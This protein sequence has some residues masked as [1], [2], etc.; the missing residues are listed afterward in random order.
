[1]L[2]RRVAQSALFLASVAISNTAF[3]ALTDEPLTQEGVPLTT[4]GCR[5]G[6]PFPISIGVNVSLTGEKCDHPC[7]AA[8][9]AGNDAIRMVNAHQTR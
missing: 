7:Y 5:I 4:S 1:M 2:L 3:V 9:L 6:H 8:L